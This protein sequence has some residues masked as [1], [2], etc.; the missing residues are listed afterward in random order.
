MRVVIGEDEALLRTGL[1]HV[2]QAA[3]FD[4]VA[5]VG[6]ARELVRSAAEHV[7]DLVVTDIRMPPDHQDAGLQAAL[8]IRRAHP[9][10]AVLVLSQHLQRAY[11]VELLGDRASGVG[12]LL[13]QRIADVDTFTDDLHRI[14]AGGTVL[15]PEVVGLM[16]ARARGQH[17]ALD[18]LTPRQ[19]QV[20]ALMSQ[21]RTNASIARTLSISERAVVQHTSHIYDQ[22]DLAL[23]DDDHRRVLAV[24][25]YLSS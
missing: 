24:I 17:D 20:L 1:T 13:K 11:A 25:R 3:G 16:V 22:L 4:V 8:E 5:A 21:G 6:D 14:A 12:Y 18:R 23:S 2:L 19:Q 10:I 15:D 7:P 9:G